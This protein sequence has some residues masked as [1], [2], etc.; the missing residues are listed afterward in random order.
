MDHTLLR[1]K[2]ASEQERRNA[3]SYANGT[4]RLHTSRLVLDVPDRDDA[5]DIF[6]I[7]GDHRAVAHNPSDY[8]SDLEEAT[9][10]IERWLRHWAD[11][12]YGYWCVREIRTGR[13]IGYCG[14]KRMHINGMPARNLIARFHPDA[15]GSGY[16]T[17]AVKA[18]LERADAHAEDGPVVARVR[19]ENLAS[20]NVA[21][22]LG[23]RRDPDMDERG[24]DGIEEV[25]SDRL[26]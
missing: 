9:E 20:R 12:E 13:I 24:P 25:F 16:A 5:A 1:I 23:L 3:S 2:R 6:A 21:L 18:A 14:T 17:E 26:T 22:K 19:P 4:R 11:H 7:V 8:V 10:L 15:W